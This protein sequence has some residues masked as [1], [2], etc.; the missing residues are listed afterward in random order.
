M[1]LPKGHTTLSKDDQPI[2][3]A[4]W[5]VEGPAGYRVGQS[6]VIKIEAYDENGSMSQVPWL[7]IFKG[8]KIVMRIAAENMSIHYE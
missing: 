3:A 2:V 7:A 5:L 1:E 6:D 8:D 4:Y